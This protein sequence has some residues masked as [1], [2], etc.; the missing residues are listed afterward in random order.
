MFLSSSN[1][2]QGGKIESKWCQAKK[3]VQCFNG[4]LDEILC[5]HNDHISVSRTINPPFIV[6]NKLQ[7]IFSVSES[8]Q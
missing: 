3:E 5:S 8:G 7:A 6:N 1:Q 2:G 4:M